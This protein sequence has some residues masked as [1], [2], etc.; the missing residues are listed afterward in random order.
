MPT[1]RIVLGST[2]ITRKFDGNPMP[3]GCTIVDAYKAA[4]A[5]SLNSEPRDDVLLEA[6]T[7]VLSETPDWRHGQI[8]VGPVAG[9]RCTS[10]LEYIIDKPIYNWHLRIFCVDGGGHQML[11]DVDLMHFDPYAVETAYRKVN[12]AAA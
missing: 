12:A 3:T 6:L 5:A 10:D 8:Q 1:A 2:M 4:H 11:A 7:K 9:C